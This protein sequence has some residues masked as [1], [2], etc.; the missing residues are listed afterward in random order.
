VLVAA[1]AV[2]VGV[3]AA[4]DVLAD[5][6][7]TRPDRI[8]AGA[9]TVVDL[10]FRGERAAADP[11]RHASHLVEF[12][13]APFRR[14]VATVAIIGRGSADARVVLDADLGEHGTTRLRGCLED[15][16]IER[17]QASVVGIS[18]VPGG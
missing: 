6:T 4:I 13:T 15:T 12:C 10:H 8:E 17:V 16:T 11:E 5:A 2:T 3:G 14:E 9:T 1:V 18:L 7:Q